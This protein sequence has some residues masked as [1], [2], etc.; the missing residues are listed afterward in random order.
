[1]S[2]SVDRDDIET[3]RLEKALAVVL[4]GFL[5]LGGVWIYSRID[6]AVGHGPTYEE[7]LAEQ[8]A[9]AAAI[10]RGDRAQSAVATA[11]QNLAEARAELELRREAYRTAL[12]AGEPAEDLRLAYEQAQADFDE[13]ERTL[14]RAEA[15]ASATVPEAAAADRRVSE[16]LESRTDR[17]ALWTFLARLGYVA[18]ALAGAFWLLNR[19]RRSGSRFLPLG[20]AAVGAATVLA[21]VLAVDYATDY[22]EITDL[23]PIVLSAIGIVLTLVSF[24]AL[25]RFLARRIPSRRVRKHE[26]PFCGFPVAD[27]ERCEGCG[28]EVIAACSSCGQPRRVG[29]AHCRACGAA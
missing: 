20:I 13:A 24:A 4:A 6:D 7:V 22:F 2:A 1:M 10:E 21:F 26:C 16:E 14:R 3:T 27:N 8:P 19:L 28:R 12:D 25:Q 15:A 29:T 11:Q 23:G 5:L 9:D 17:A 18:A